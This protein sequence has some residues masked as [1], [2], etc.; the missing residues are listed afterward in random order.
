MICL[1]LFHNKTV[2]LKRIK[3]P[4]YLKSLNAKSMKNKNYLLYCCYGDKSFEHNHAFTLPDIKF[5]SVKL[6]LHRFY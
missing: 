6:G 5:K 4:L 1:T 2:G 3:E